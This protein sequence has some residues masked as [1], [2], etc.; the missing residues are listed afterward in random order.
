MPVLSCV[1]L[2]ELQT[3]TKSNGSSYPFQRGCSGFKNALV[4]FNFLTV[5]WSSYNG[6]VFCT[7]L[8]S[9]CLCRRM[10]AGL[11]ILSPCSFHSSLYCFLL[12][13]EVSLRRH[14]E[15]RD[16]LFCALEWFRH[17]EDAEQLCAE[18][19]KE[20]AWTYFN[21]LNLTYLTSAFW[22]MIHLC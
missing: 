12:Y 16:T 15:V 10:R 22:E 21:Y 4:Y 3:W 8:L 5:F 2:G 7:F 9:Q 18:W 1:S 6:I 11:P 19:R 13:M 17:R 14:F 20:L